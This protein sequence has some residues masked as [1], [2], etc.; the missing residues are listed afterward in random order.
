VLV[1]LE[2][3]EIEPSDK[4]QY[5]REENIH[6]GYEAGAF[7]EDDWDGQGAW[8][9][10]TRKTSTSIHVQDNYTRWIRQRVDRYQETI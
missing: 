2:T 4:S 7:E 6:W 8:I 1:S 9:L 5:F 3:R 10:V